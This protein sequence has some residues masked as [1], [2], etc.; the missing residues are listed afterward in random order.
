MVFALKPQKSRFSAY[1]YIA[2]EEDGVVHLDLIRLGPPYL[3][4]EA[5]GLEQATSQSPHR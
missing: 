1:L 5:I 4:Q 3:F 2:E